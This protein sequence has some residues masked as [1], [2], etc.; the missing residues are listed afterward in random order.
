[1]LSLFTETCVAGH[2]Q[3]RVL[4]LPILSAVVP[5]GLL[6]YITTDG[7]RV[8]GPN[9]EAANEVEAWGILHVIHRLDD[10]IGGV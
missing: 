1:M 2:V 6:S 4:L 7:Q 3:L 5:R 10:S 8:H 9:Q